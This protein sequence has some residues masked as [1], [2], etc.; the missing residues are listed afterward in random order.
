MRILPTIEKSLVRLA[1]AI[2][3]ELTVRSNQI[4]LV[5][6]PV[7][8]WEAGSRIAR[9]VRRAELRGWH[10]AAALLS[11]DLR[12]SLTS[13]ESQLADILRELPSSTV[14]ERLVTTSDIYE[15]LVALG[16]EFEAVNYD[17][18]GR[19]LSVTT[20]PLDLEGVFLG[21][22]EIRLDWRR[23]EHTYRVIATD[24]HPPDT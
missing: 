7:N 18:N 11:T 6:L 22:F 23:G 17:R 19:W 8:A 21:P 13:F 10:L 5:D 3:D 12:Y 14:T 1:I 4:R 20:E 9:Q 15:D 16:E 2:R 24:P